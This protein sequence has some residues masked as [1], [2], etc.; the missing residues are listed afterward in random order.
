MVNLERSESAYILQ[1]KNVAVEGGEI[2]VRCVVPVVEDDTERFPVFVNIHGG[3]KPRY[4]GAAVSL[5]TRALTFMSQDGQSVALNW[6][7]TS[8]ANFLSI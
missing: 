7:T 8:C 1:D 4:S 2:I 3:G 6:T 5:K